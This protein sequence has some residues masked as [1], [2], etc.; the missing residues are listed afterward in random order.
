MCCSEK[1]DGSAHCVRDSASARFVRLAY[2][3]LSSCVAHV[4]LANDVD[5]AIGGMSSHIGSTSLK[6]TKA[7]SLTLPSTATACGP[8]TSSW[9]DAWAPGGIAHASAINASSADRA[10]SAT[11]DARGLDATI[12]PADRGRGARLLIPWRPSLIIATVPSW[13]S[14]GHRRVGCPETCARASRG[15]RLR[16]WNPLRDWR[17][18]RSR[19]RPASQRAALC[20]PRRAAYRKRHR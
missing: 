9:L 1:A 16:P 20:R 8:A 10:S 14:L 12:A 4:V 2:V 13:R 17:V 15:S 6:S 19:G 5:S 7:T 11:D 18:K 3:V